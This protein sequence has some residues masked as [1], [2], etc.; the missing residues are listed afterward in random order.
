VT[1]AGGHAFSLPRGSH[2][3]LSMH[4]RGA[5]FT[6]APV[7]A[8]ED[9]AFAGEFVLPFPGGL[10]DPEPLRIA[11]IAAE[12]RHG[13][14]RLVGTHILDPRRAMV[15]PADGSNARRW[16]REWD[17]MEHVC[18]DCFFDKNLPSQEFSISF[19]LIHMA[20]THTYHPHILALSLSLEVRGHGA[21]SSSPIGAIN[22]RLAVRPAPARAPLAAELAAQRRLERSLRSAA[23]REFYDEAKA[24]WDAYRQ[25]THGVCVAMYF[26]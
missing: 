25:E 14:G 7:A 26:F 8:C 11:V 1:L 15:A 19:A 13:P 17:R 5:R 3:T 2:V 12:D 10:R 9:P 16:W 24:F 23:E 20:H 4:H 6:T 22:L 18:F 21:L